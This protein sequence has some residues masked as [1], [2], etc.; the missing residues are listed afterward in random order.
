MADS[1]AVT[2]LVMACELAD[3]GEVMTDEQDVPSE[4]SRP[5]FDP[6]RDVVLVFEVERL[7]AYA[8]VHGARGAWGS[9]HPDH[10]GRGIGS[11]LVEWTEAHARRQ[12]GAWVGQTVSENEAGTVTLLTSRG[13]RPRWTSWVLEID[14]STR[15]AHPRSLEGAIIRPFRPGVDD[16][17]VY[18][19]IEDAFGEW[20]DRT[21][22]TFEDWSA[23]TVGRSD[24]DPELVWVAVVDLRIV[25]VALGFVAGE[26]GWVQQLA[27]ERSHRGLGLGKAL[28]QQAFRT[29]HD[30]G[31]R[32]GGLS[33]NSRT[34][35]LG[36]YEH[37]GMRVRRTYTQFALEL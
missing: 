20:P 26:G 12:G 13:Y 31:A 27:V 16:W 8:E 10:R 9:V 22:T 30:R 36:L 33:T 7:V 35:A 15:P 29:F 5:S 18:R 28:L 21:P 19:V 11:A 25:G 23:L 3:D 17:A 14:L 24:F 1:G 2:K 6:S 32:K 37:V 34:G 4:W